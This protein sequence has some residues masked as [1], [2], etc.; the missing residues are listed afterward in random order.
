MDDEK[1]IKGPSIFLTADKII[2]L[3]NQLLDPVFLL[4]VADN[5]RSGRPQQMI[6]HY[7]FH[8]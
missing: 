2:I 6:S 5:V 7:V 8:N 4:I 1:A 3:N